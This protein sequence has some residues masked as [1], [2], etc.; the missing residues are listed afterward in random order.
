MCT[1]HQAGLTFQCLGW[2][3]R[4]RQDWAGEWERIPAHCWLLEAAWMVLTVQWG[5]PVS[6]VS[7]ALSDTFPLMPPL[8]DLK[9]FP[10]LCLCLCHYFLLS[11]FENYQEPQ[12]Q[13]QTH[14]RPQGL[15]LLSPDASSE[16]P[17]APRLT[18]VFTRGFHLVK[19]F[20]GSWVFFFLRK[21]YAKKF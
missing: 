4:R 13:L 14:P 5:A 7:S 6:L 18:R 15:L 8:R 19:M 20:C 10:V 9:Y 17:L 2:R 11:H 21:H 16:T 3:P 12:R 1:L